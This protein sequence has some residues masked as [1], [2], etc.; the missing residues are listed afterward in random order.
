[1]KEGRKEGILYLSHDFHIP[2]TFEAIL[3]SSIR[4]FTNHFLDG[5]GRVVQRVDAVRGSPFT[6]PIELARINI[7]GDDFLAAELDT[8]YE[9]TST[10]NINNEINNNGNNYRNNDKNNK[11]NNNEY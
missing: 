9:V 1:M 2:D 4:Q 8:C 6:S 10:N 3:H 5:F 11:V 7:D